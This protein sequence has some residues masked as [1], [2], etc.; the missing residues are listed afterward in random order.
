MA[1]VAITGSTGFVGGNI[2]EA[3]IQMGFE[4]VGL[5]RKAG[6]AGF[7]W[8]LAVVDFQSE[9]SIAQ[10]LAG[11]DA[12]VHCAIHNDFNKLVN[13]REFAYD[14][15][16]GMTQRVTRAANKVGAQT[17]YISSDW[18][19]DG[20]GHFTKESDPGNP[21]NFYG[22]LKALGEQVVRD[23]AP[24]TGAVCRIG[25]VMG[26]HRT[27][28][29]MPRGQDVGFGYFVAS[30]VQTLRD[31]KEFVVWG[32]DRVNKVATPSLASEIGAEISRIIDKKVGGTFHLVG[33]DAVTRMELAEATCDVFGL[34]KNLLKTG[35]PPV[36]ALFP[37]GVPVDTSLSNKKTKEVLGL[38]PTSVKDLLNAFKNEW[39]S[40]KVSP[41]TKRSA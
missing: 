28:K 25:G 4:V 14:S 30:I 32:G 16:V 39:E 18:I 41:I 37:S 23:L 8:P 21:I 12:V 35:E 5:S 2:A 15:F 19:M 36:E 13:D 26:F 9:A 6:E 34:D 20:D 24:D 10:G 27:K 29:E 11:C 3:L 31:G 40:G 22:A 7:P 33:D 1:K 38:G 17:I